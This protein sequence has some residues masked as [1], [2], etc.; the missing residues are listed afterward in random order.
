MTTRFT[1][2]IRRVNT[3]RGH[4][5]LDAHGARVPGVTTIIGDG[6]PKPA[7]INWAANATADAAVNRW[8]ELAGLPPAQRL[9]AL[10]SARYEDK[11]RAANRG[12]Q[13]HMLA[14]RLVNG[15]QVQAP[16]EIAGHVEAYAR[17]LDEYQVQP[18]FIEFS[19]ASH[20]HG[21]AG[22]GDL[23]CKLTIPRRGVLLALTDLKTNRSGIFGETSLQLSAYRYADVLIT[24]AGEQPMPE[25]DDT[26]AVH[27][28]G[29][30]ADLIPV[31]T[32]PD[33]FRAFLYAQ[34]VARW[35]KDSRDL[36]GA[37][38]ERPAASTYR[39]VREDQ[40]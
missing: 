10:K 6:I 39:L 27:V 40:Q 20:K 4:K 9:A 15:E 37:P 13:V 19:I 31:T 29:D 16:D 34:Q 36:V 17:F 35:A 14:E 33:T 28:R 24:A 3:A 2:P 22:T 25:V 32:T 7:L 5:Y 38:V 11:D 1:A 21:Y 30:G 26:F 12:T 8:D 18:V 23:I